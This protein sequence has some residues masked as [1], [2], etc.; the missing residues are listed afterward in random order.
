MCRS[1]DIR[2]TNESKT[3]FRGGGG[4]DNIISAYAPQVVEKEVNKEGF[5]KDLEC[6]I[7]NIPEGKKFIIGAD[8][9]AHS[10]EVGEGYRRIHG[11]KGYGKRNAE[12]QKVLDSLEGLDMAVVNIFFKKR[13]KQKITYK[14]GQGQS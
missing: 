7:N 5:A 2:Q 4:D 1:I 10:G 11:G 8:L 3:D 14:S 9:N 12:G 13:E 6:M